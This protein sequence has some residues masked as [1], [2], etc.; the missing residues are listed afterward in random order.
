MDVG[1]TRATNIR[2][3][4]PVD[5]TAARKEHAARSRHRAH[6]ADA[7]AEALERVVRRPVPV[8]GLVEVELAHACLSSPWP[9]APIQPT[10]PAAWG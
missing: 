1:P 5:V 4:A 6:S 2:L 8:L 3:P 9:R 7:V 10:T